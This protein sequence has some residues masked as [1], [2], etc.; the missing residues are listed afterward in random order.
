MIN[1]Y[2]TKNLMLKIIFIL[3]LVVCFLLIVF[4][5]FVGLKN[6]SFFDGI[7]ILF[8]DIPFIGNF[9]DISGIDKVKLIIIKEIRLPRIILG[10]VVGAGL[11]ISGASLQSLFKNPLVE[12]YI[13]G[14][15]SGA[16]LGATI[17]I[18]IG[19]KLTFLGMGGIVIFAFI[20]SIF[21]SLLLLNFGGFSRKQSSSVFLLIG[22]SISLFFSSIVSLLM[23]LNRNKIENIILWIMGSLSNASWNK[24]YIAT[25]FI[26]IGFVGLFLL[27]KSLNVISLD[28]DVAKS[29]GINV[30][31][32]KYLILIFTSLVTS[33]SV[34]TTGII[35]F[36]GLIIPHI[37]RLLFGYDNRIILPFSAVIGSIFL[38]CSDMIAKSLVYPSEIPIGVITSFIGTPIFLYLITRINRD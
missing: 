20:G 19:S 1:K 12:P 27:S 22:I 29:T 30:T 15:S 36:I 16:T 34:A 9:F 21:T 2:K 7:K 24:V 28:E 8:S 33:V 5:C 32:S 4:F 17:A 3:L 10:I 18:I 23:I 14:I 35:G 37:V 13:T 26:I 6:I 11:A 25:P 38:I 31:K